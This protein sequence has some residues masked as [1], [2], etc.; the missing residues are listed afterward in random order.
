MRIK[1]LGDITSEAYKKV[2]ELIIGLGHTLTDDSN[3]DLQVAPLLTKIT[4]YSELSR[5]SLGTL[6]FHP[7][8]LPYGRGAAAIKYAYKRNEPL[9]AATWFWANDGKVDSGDICE[10]E[11]VKI[12]HELRPR[13][14][15]S[16][17]IIPGMLRALER[18]LKAIDSGY[19]RRV[20]QVEEYASFDYK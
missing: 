19:V 5:P 16:N 6:I 10:S 14:F 3:C 13:D 7:S 18:A 2:S 11:I 9:T 12:K 1:L 4:P 8:P 17:H 15:Y 20:K